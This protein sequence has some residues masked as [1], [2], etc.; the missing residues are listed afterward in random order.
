MSHQLYLP[1]FE[2]PI[3]DIASDCWQTP[4]EI[5]G[6]AVQV[7]GSIDLDPA[8]TTTNPTQAT[9]FYTIVEDGLAQQWRGRVFLN[10]PY[11]KPRPWIKKIAESYQFGEVTEA[12]A[13]L[14]SRCLSNKGTSPDIGRSAAA[15]CHCYGRIA[16]IR[17]GTAVTG[18]DFDSCL[19][20]WG[21]NL[22]AFCTAFKNFGIVS[23][24][25]PF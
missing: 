2:Q 22:K 13:L 14:P 18:T 23:I 7:M 4:P 19:V 20:Y 24:I 8:T 6:L 11:S 16:F 21:Q 1:G 10:P 25:H 3:I 15:L 5:I 9:Q 12:I 17:D